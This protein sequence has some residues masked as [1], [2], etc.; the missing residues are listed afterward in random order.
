VIEMRKIALRKPSPTIDPDLVFETYA[1]L[2]Q[3]YG[4]DVDQVR[5]LAAEEAQRQ[6]RYRRWDL[7]EATARIV[8]ARKLP[9]RSTIYKP[10]SKTLPVRPRLERRF[11]DDE[12]QPPKPIAEETPP[13][14]TVIVLPEAIGPTWGT[15]KRSE[16]VVRLE[17]ARKLA[18]VTASAEAAPP[19]VASPIS[20]RIAKRSAGMPARAKRKPARAKRKPARAKPQTVA[21]R[22][23]SARA[24]TK[25]KPTKARSN[26]RRTR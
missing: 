10:A 7:L 20:E 12:F 17:A 11:L 13:P 4:A 23:T 25:R 15:R 26:R 18:Y 22:R 5:R 14:P 19:G 16:L 3:A 2:K 6:A 1:S 8:G 9:P 24:A 21:K